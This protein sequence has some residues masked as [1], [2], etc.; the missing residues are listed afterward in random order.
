ME[1][2][3]LS[4]LPLLL[5]V[6]C[7]NKDDTRHT[8]IQ[9]KIEQQDSPQEISVSQLFELTTTLKP[10]IIDV[11]TQKEFSSGHIPSAKNI[12][13]SELSEKLNDLQ[14]YQNQNIYLV[15]AVGGRSGQAQQHLNTLGFSTINVVGGTEEWKQKQYPL[16]LPE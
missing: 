3:M 11:R 8:Q 10:V 6:L 4:N 16:K 1:Y 7:C 14:L 12:P 5:A 13:L 2:D 15:C 9:T